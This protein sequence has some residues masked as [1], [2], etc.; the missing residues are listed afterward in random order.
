MTQSLQS[1]VILP[2]SH[3]E[4]VIQEGD[5]Y[6]DRIL[7]KKNK[8]V[9]EVMPEY[10]AAHVVS[11]D[12]RGEIKEKDILDLLVPDQEWLAVELYKLKYDQIMELTFGCPH[13]GHVDTDKGLDLGKLEVIPVPEGAVGPDPTFEV[14]LPRSGKK[15][16]IG[17]LD[18][19]K[20]RFLM[21]LEAS[22][23][24]DID[25]NQADFK[26][27]R[28]L[29]GVSVFSYEDVAMLP[30]K[31]HAVIRRARKKL[32]CGYDTNV[33]VECDSCGRKTVINILTHRDF[34]LPG[35]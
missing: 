17:F 27:L 2:I 25:L 18:G 29:D 21:E 4:V 30:P 23:G 20:E 15:A 24:G 19:H 9:F 28:E 3:K 26:A 31:D 12:G 10:L 33:I 32:I 16:R 1:T 8:R 14:V 6:L 22:T 5:G 34:L 11:I 35:G 7:L 13:C